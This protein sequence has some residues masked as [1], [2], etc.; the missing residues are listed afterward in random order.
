MGTTVR[1]PE[2]LK[3]EAELYA[4]AVGISLNALVAVALRDYLDARKRDAPA[5][6]TGSRGE[7][8]PG[9]VAR[10]RW[11]PVTLEEREREAEA[12]YR[13][14]SGDAGGAQAVSQRAPCPCG[15]GKKY[16]HCHGRPA[17]GMGRPAP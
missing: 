8:A 14:G 15:S 6:G 9:A 12:V 3:A 5:V 16:K 11:D 4:G 7:P 17:R 1:F 2:P 13:S 10:P